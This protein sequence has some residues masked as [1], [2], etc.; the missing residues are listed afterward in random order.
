[1]CDHRHFRL[2]QSGMSRNASMPVAER[3]V[4]PMIGLVMHRWRS[5]GPPAGDRPE[6]TDPGP[7]AIHP[8]QMLA[9]A[10]SWSSIFVPLR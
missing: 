4:L 2:I 9:G 5:A 3:Q 1:L 7:T 10:L 6:D 8:M